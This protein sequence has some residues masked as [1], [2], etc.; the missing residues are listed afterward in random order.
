MQLTLAPRLYDVFVIA[1]AARKEITGSGKIPR[2]RRNSLAP[3]LATKFVL[4]VTSMLYCTGILR[5]G[6][7]QAYRVFCSPDSLC[8]IRVCRGLLWKDPQ[9]LGGLG[10]DEERPAGHA[11]HSPRSAHRLCQGDL[12]MAICP[13]CKS[14]KKQCLIFRNRKEYRYLIFSIFHQLYEILLAFFLTW[15]MQLTLIPC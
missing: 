8:V 9:G 11:L 15:I 4:G 14:L 12:V 5:S 6:A 3:A 13:T 1:G 10:V 2:L 7:E